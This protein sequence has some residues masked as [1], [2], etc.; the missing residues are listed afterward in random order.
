MCCNFQQ[1]AGGVKNGEYIAQL[2]IDNILPSLDPHR[3]GV[4]DAIFFDGA[5]NV[6]LA[7]EMIKVQYPRMTVLKG[8][9]HVMNLFFMDCATKIPFIA[10]LVRMYCKSLY[11]F[12]GSG[13]RHKVY[14]IFMEHSRSWNGGHAIGFTKACGLRFA[15]FFIAL[16]RLLCN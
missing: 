8:A 7:G 13:G 3:Q 12:M 10:A 1:A 6:Q 11:P 5:S 16:L 9:E 2:F 15:G 4:V 14:S